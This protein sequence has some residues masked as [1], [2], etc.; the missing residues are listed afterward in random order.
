MMRPNNEPGP[1]GTTDNGFSLDLKPFGNREL[2]ESYDVIRTTDSRSPRYDDILAVLQYSKLQ[3]NPLDATEF[4]WTE[5]E[6]A[7]AASEPNSKIDCSAV[8]T[9][10]KCLYQIEPT[11]PP[12]GVSLGKGNQSVRPI[13]AALRLEKW[14]R[15]NRNGIRML[16]SSSK[17]RSLHMSAGVGWNDSLRTA[18]DVDVEYKDF[19]SELGVQ[20]N[21]LIRGMLPNGFKLYQSK[22]DG[23][24][25]KLSDRETLDGLTFGD[26]D[27]HYNHIHINNIFPAE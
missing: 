22:T 27:I 12:N 15:H 3:K 19:L 6:C 25:V 18:L 20:E 16:I 14:V 9:V 21:L 11:N 1:L 5:R 4:M 2:G 8:L 7:K 10:E 13:N 17:S 26:D 24:L 23:T